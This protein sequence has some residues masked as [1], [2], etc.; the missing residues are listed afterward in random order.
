MLR[1]QKLEYVFDINV[2]SIYYN[3]TDYLLNPDGTCVRNKS[4]F[5]LKIKKRLTNKIVNF[6]YM[7]IYNLDRVPV[8]DI[9]RTVNNKALVISGTV[10]PEKSAFLRELYIETSSTGVVRGVKRDLYTIRAEIEFSV[11]KDVSVFKYPLEDEFFISSDGKK[12]RI[13]Y[14]DDATLQNIKNPIYSGNCGFGYFG[15]NPIYN[16]DEKIPVNDLGAVLS[17]NE[18]LIYSTVYDCRFS[19]WNCVGFPNEGEYKL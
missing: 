6:A 2:D 14:V 16:V 12:Y 10:I 13:Q 8:D 11:E 15:E 7:S 5:P 19:D 9:V 3:T 18:P 4:G 1:A 17:T